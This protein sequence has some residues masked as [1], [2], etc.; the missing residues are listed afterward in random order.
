MSKRHVANVGLDFFNLFAG[1]ELAGRVTQYACEDRLL[2]PEDAFKL[3][4]DI[5]FDCRIT[6]VLPV[7]DNAQWGEWR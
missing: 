3:G 1:V 7:L 2:K 4:A 5:S 6:L